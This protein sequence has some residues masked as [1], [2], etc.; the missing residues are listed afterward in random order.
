MREGRVDEASAHLPP[1][2]GVVAADND[3][4]RRHAQVAQRAM[5]AHRLLSLVIDLRLDDKE[6]NVAVRPSL[7]ASIRAEQDY[8]R[9]RGSRSQA[10]PGLGNQGLVNYL[11]RPNRSRDPRSPAKKGDDVTSQIATGQH[12]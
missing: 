7:P 2:L 8:L 4:V 1:T 6:V 3:H 12:G 11:H 9:F 10:T 5:E